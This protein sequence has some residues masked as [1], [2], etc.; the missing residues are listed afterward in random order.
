M[1]LPLVSQFIHLWIAFRTDRFMPNRFAQFSDILCSHRNQI[2]WIWS[3]GISIRS[4]WEAEKSSQKTKN[5]KR[6]RGRKE[7]LK[8]LPIIIV[9]AYFKW[10][11]KWKMHAHAQTNQIAIDERYM[12]NL[13]DR[14]VIVIHL[15][16]LQPFSWSTKIVQKKLWFIPGIRKWRKKN[17]SK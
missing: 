2:T 6:R 3:Q 9:A 5:K 15:V 14:P 17:R 10:F 8:W 12:N 7:Q 11:L 4:R 13:P 16:R 1:R